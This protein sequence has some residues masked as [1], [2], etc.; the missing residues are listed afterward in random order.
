MNDVLYDI[1]FGEYATDIDVVILNSF[2]AI[3]IGLFIMLLYR[4]TYA[5]PAYSKKFNVSLGMITIVVTIIMNLIAN[6]VALSLGLVGALSV[7]RFRAAVKDSRDATFIFWAV[8]MG[9]A[10]GISQYLAGFVGSSAIALFLILTQ[11]IR[12]EGRYLLIIRSELTSQIEV[13]K[14]IKYYYHKKA[15]L[16]VV[17]QYDDQCDF[18][19]EISKKNLDKYQKLSG[20]LSIF[21]VFKNVEGIKSIDLIQQNDDISV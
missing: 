9:I 3:F 16:R 10:C 15:N 12:Y 14:K 2:A 17:K 1:L 6:S 7:I 19:Y 13:E 21:E 18:I 5:G 20:G 4:I 11:Q 8:A